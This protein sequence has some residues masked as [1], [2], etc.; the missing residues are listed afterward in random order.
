MPQELSK[1]TQ[2]VVFP[3]DILKPSGSVGSY[4]AGAG[5][6]VSEDGSIRAS[7][8]G[9]VIIDD[10]DLSNAGSNSSGLMKTA[11]APR[12]SVKSLKCATT[13]RDY[14]IDV[15]DVVCCRVIRTNYNQ[16]FVDIL[17]VGDVPLPFP[18]KG[19]IRREDVRSEEVDKVVL[20]DFFTSGDIVRATVIS[21]GDSKHYFLS[22]AAEGMGVIEYGPFR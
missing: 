8:I 11:A 15:Q 3:G 7:L 4:I 20:R 10:N 13:A 21:L 12:V 1:E 2:Q 14:V 18:G 9:T 19:V 17:T 5:T 16:A 6:F 22:T